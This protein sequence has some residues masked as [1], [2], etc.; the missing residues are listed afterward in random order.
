[1]VHLSWSSPCPHTSNG[2]KTLLIS[3][4]A[5]PTWGPLKT[6]FDKIKK[7]L[8][9]TSSS[10]QARPKVYR[11]LSMIFTVWIFT[12]VMS[13]THTLCW[14]KWTKSANCTGWIWLDDGIN[15]DNYM[16][17]E[18]N[19]TKSYHM[20]MFGQSLCLRK[21]VE[22]LWASYP[23]AQPLNLCHSIS[24]KLAHQPKAGA[25]TGS[26]RGSALQPEPKTWHPT[27]ITTAE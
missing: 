20:D 7:I 18:W 12:S 11:R 10:A 2:L 26:S 22:H 16:Y 3:H 14:Q 8:H 9:S 25:A 4:M 23:W 24:Q 19:H 6:L 1:M 21:G 15:Y 13:H 5:K 27:T 17:L